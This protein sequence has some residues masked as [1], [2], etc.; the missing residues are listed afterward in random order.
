M[1]NFDF[2]KFGDPDFKIWNTVEDSFILSFF[3]PFLI[4]QAACLKLED[5]KYAFMGW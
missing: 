2:L 4:Y 1:Y 5:S 3:N